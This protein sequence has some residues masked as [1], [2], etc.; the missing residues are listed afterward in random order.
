MKAIAFICVIACMT[1]PVAAQNRS[2]SEFQVKAVFLYNFTQFIDW[3][4]SALGTAGE[5]FIIGIIGDDP[6]GSYLDDVVAGE[7]IGDHPILVIRIQN[8]RQVQICHMLYVSNPNQEHVE[9]ILLY[10]GKRNILTVGEAPQFCRMG[11]IVR[12]YTE[13]NK[14]RLEINVARAKEAQLNISS[15]LLS[16]AKTNPDEK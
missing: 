2:A 6:F 16:L 1:E 10:A 13:E 15:K 14:I 5:P 12:F 3:P 9:D 7:K 11:G 8:V 4:D